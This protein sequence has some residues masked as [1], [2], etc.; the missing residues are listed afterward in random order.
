MW[1]LMF[2]KIYA[3]NTVLSSLAGG[4]DPDTY[5][6]WVWLFL[7][8]I[9][10]LECHVIIWEN[11]LKLDRGND[12]LTSVDCTDCRIPNHGPDFASHKFNK[13]G[14]RYEIALCIL[15]G[16]VVWL[17]GPFECGKWPDISIFQSALLG[18]LADNERV[19][20]DDGY[21]GDHPMY[22]KCP[23][24]F[25][26]PE[27]TLFMRQSTS[28]AQLDSPIRRRLSSCG[29]EFETGRKQSTSE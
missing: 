13:S 12:C 6:K 11:Q 18:M 28:N 23:A 8:G 7:D 29:R 2:L 17:N 9:V 19:E 5:M 20:A 14:L 22:I 25:A 1:T 15:T 24:G 21:V 10:Y 16:D 26:N 27:E 3:R 4:V